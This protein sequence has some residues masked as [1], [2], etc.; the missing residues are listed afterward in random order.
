MERKTIAIVALIFTAAAIVSYWT[1]AHTYAIPSI[2]GP[3]YYIQVNSI[4]NTGTV[5]YADPP[6][7]FYI[8]TLFT[9]ILSNTVTGVMVGSAVFAGAAAVAVYFLFKH[10]FKTQVPAIAAGV[11]TA[12]S[13]EHIAMSVNL[14]KNALGVVFIVGVIFFLQRCLDSE[15]QAKWNVVG[16]IG[17]FLLTMLTHVLD[18]GVALLFIGGYLIFSL[19]FSE[20]KQ[21]LIKFGTIFGAAIA[22]AVG[23]FLLVPEY[24]GDFNKGL[25]FVST[26]SSST[27]TS[28]N[29]GPGGIGA[30]GGMGVADPF[31]YAFL[32]LGIALS[33]YEWLR[34]DKKKSVL[35]ASASVIGI[36]LVLP[37]IPADFAWRFQL[38]EFLSVAIIGGYTCSALLR[39]NRRDLAIVAMI[40]MLLPVAFVGYQTAVSFS[41]T[42]S[43][44]GY[45]DLQQM[46]SS[47]TKENSV[48]L[49]QGSGGTMA[50]WPEY[51]LGLEVVSNSSLYL[52][53]G[54]NVYVLVGSQAQTGMLG[55]NF[56]G[57]PGMGGNAGL[58]GFGGPGGLLS[59]PTQGGMPNGG[60]FQNGGQNSANSAVSLTNATLV[61]SG[62]VYSLYKL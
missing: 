49:V 52:E 51:L 56:S 37:F 32:A 34:G 25:I 31:V 42:I 39:I 43:S 22:C 26:V 10:I 53:Q 36:L 41:P 21:L 9:L 20:R 46:A 24:F 16:A 7:T 40:A 47:I 5:Q 8:F 45:T 58:G 15:K 1:M 61:Y 23:G 44:Q 27:S 55:N 14:M 4:L 59:P 54:Y 2:D 62:T 35:V 11:V 50:Y 29:F 3:Y 28:N 17:F 13:A 6:L 19:T 57:P 38:M 48:L 33:I 60:G 30:G 12:I 18:E